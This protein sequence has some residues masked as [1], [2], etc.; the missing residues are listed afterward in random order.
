MDSAQGQRA[1]V[2]HRVDGIRRQRHY[3]LLQLAHIARNHWQV[4]FGLD[5]DLDVVATL[6]MSNQTRGP[7]DQLIHIDGGALSGA[8]AT[9]IE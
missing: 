9:K 2:R 6:L 5:R 3:S 8:Q 1:S 7:L 4:L